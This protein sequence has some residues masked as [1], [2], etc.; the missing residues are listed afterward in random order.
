MHGDFSP[1]CCPGGSYASTHGSHVPNGGEWRG[2]ERP[3]LFASRIGTAG[4]ADVHGRNI[5]AGR[6]P[7]YPFSPLAV[8]Q[9]L[10][11]R[12]KAARLPEILSPHS[13][14][15]LVVTD[16]LSETVPH[17]DVQLSAGHAHHSTNQIYDHPRRRVSH[18]F[19]KQISL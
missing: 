10:K 2:R 8:V 5:P 14:R 17:D 13:F 3:P 16:L 15:A 12:L 7:E 4:Q 18:N 1:T 9:M 6:L 19:F 11:C